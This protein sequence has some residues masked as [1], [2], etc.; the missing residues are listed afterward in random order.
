M[1]VRERIR[2]FR[3]IRVLEWCVRWYA[4]HPPGPLDDDLEKKDVDED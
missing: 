1:L 4:R 3:W 2:W